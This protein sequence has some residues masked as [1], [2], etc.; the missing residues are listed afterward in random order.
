MHVSL[1]KKDPTR[2]MFFHFKKR[3]LFLQF[4]E[5]W[6]VLLSDLRWVGGFLR[7]LRFLLQ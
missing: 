6:I 1:R 2:S 5:I 3:I 7:A 4:F